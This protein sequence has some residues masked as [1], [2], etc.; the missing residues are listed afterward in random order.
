MLINLKACLIHVERLHGTSRAID[1]LKDEEFK[2]SLTEQLWIIL[3]S[4]NLMAYHTGIVEHIMSKIH[5]SP[6]FRVDQELMEDMDAVNKI[7]RMV[8]SILTKMQGIMKQK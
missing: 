4:P 7:K 2:S 6:N 5:D 3:I 1:K 8:G